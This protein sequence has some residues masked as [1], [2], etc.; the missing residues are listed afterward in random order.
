VRR[1]EPSFAL[2]TFRDQGA[3]LCVLILMPKYHLGLDSEG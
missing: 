3:T 2:L 1:H